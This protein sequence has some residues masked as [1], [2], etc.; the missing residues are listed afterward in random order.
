MIRTQVQLTD[1]PAQALKTLS[2]RTGL[3]I[4]ELIRRS[5]DPILRGG[6][7]LE[8]NRTQRALAVVGKFHSGH[9]NISAEHDLYLDEP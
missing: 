7:L 8:Q 4:A 2:A 5:L 1:E 6:L 9:S 3:S